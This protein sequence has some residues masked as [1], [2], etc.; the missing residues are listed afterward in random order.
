M[1]EIG[2][3]VSVPI[4]DVWENGETEF[5]KWLAMHPDCLEDAI[6][7]SISELWAEHT[8]GGIRVDLVGKDDA[9]HTIIVENQ[10]GESN[11]DHLG[12]LIT[13]IAVKNADIAVWIVEHARA[14]HVKAIGLLNQLVEKRF[15]LVSMEAVKIG[16]SMPALKL[17]LNIGP[18]I[19]EASPSPYY[20]FWTGLIKKL[21]ERKI[22]LHS[23]VPPN[24]RH[25]IEAS[26]GVIGIKLCYIIRNSDAR[27]QLHISRYPTE[28]ENEKIYKQFQDHRDE[29]DA[30]FGQPLEWQELEGRRAFRIESNIEIGGLQNSDKWD[31]IQNEMIGKMMRFEKAFRS[32]IIS[33]N[34][35]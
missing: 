21:K 7:I 15:Y 32:H 31:E 34:V 9:E 22:I 29:I 1:K 3:I 20:Q 14:E 16:D 30:A 17:S 19:V 2:Q 6:G 23:E 24:D 4:R 5:T 33:L 10:F 26:A 27:V 28:I 18:D 12:K 25:W 35:N 13:Y 11:H 8:I